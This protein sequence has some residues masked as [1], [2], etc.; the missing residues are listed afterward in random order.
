MRH[1]FQ[2]AT[3]VVVAAEVAVMVEAAVDAVAISTPTFDFQ[4]IWNGRNYTGT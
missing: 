4:C 3:V 2:V 1:F